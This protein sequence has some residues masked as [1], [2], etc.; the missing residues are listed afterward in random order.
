MK[1]ILILLICS[2][3]YINAQSIKAFSAGTGVT[4]V[5]NVTPSITQSVTGTFLVVITNVSSGSEA[6]SMYWLGTNNSS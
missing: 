4:I 2:C 1:K 5:Y 6:V 3:F